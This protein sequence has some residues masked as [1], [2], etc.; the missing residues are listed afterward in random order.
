M[1]GVRLVAK[2]IDAEQFASEYSAP[3]RRG[4]EAIHF[5]NTT[6]AKAA[7]NYAPGKD[8]EQGKIV[9]APVASSGFLSCKGTVDCI[10]TAVAETENMTIFVAARTAVDG[11]VAADRPMFFG[12][13]QGFN[14]DGGVA[15]GVS[16]Y[17]SGLNRITGTAGFGVDAADNTNIVSGVT[18]TVASKWG[19]YMLQVSAAG[20]TIRD[21]TTGLSQTIAPA[22]RPRRL[23][24]GKVRIG[25]GQTGLLGACDVAIFQAHNVVLTEAEIQ[26]TVADHRAYLARRGIVV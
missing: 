23:A 2:G 3:V 17:L 26:A 10:E 4:L 21:F 19:L 12:N 7:K 22:G 20:T 8:K 24:L 25:S 15:W 6:P 5:L 13:Y 1:S 11:S 18:R 14:I 9:G 16:L